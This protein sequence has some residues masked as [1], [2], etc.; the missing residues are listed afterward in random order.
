M[1]R[2]SF[3]YGDCCQPSEAAY[4]PTM[5]EQS[6]TA[7]IF[8]LATHE[9]YGIDCHQPTRW[10]LT[11]PFHPYPVRGGS[12]LLH[13]LCHY[14]TFPLGSM[15]LC[16]ARTFLLVTMHTA[17]DHSTD[18]SLG[19]QSYN[20]FATLSVCGVNLDGKNYRQSL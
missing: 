8:G 2:L 13:Y 5:D 19:L 12:F 10:A 15:V 7:G 9:M 11:P 6:L 18:V 17:T 4:P 3:I 1:E 20:F 14:S 16:V